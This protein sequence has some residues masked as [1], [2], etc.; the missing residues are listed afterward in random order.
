MEKAKLILKIILSV[1]VAAAL[2]STVLTYSLAG[3]VVSRELTIVTEATPYPPEAAVFLA[4]LDASIV[5]NIFWLS[6]AALGFCLIFLYYLYGNAHIFL[7]PSIL[8]LIIFILFQVALNLLPGYF[9]A[10]LESPLAPLL[11]EGLSK[12]QRAN[13]MVLILGIVLLVVALKYK[14]GEK[15]AKR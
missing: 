13:I 11:L 7:A 9:S 8:A 15:A 10:G 4:S 5:Q 14:T 6:L 1:A 3:I 12:A 2:V